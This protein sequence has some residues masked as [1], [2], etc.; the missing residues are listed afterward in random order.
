[1]TTFIPSLLP[2]FQVPAL[3]EGQRIALAMVLITLLFSL[4][5]EKEFIR[6]Y[7]TENINNWRGAINPFAW[8]LLVAFAFLMA[9]RFLGFIFN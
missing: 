5:V 1:M 6:A 4:L 8:P 9:S 7:G 2:I 3:T